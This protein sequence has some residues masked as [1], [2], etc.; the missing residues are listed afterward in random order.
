LDLA[1]APGFLIWK[2]LLLLSSRAVPQHWV[3]TARS[4]ERD[5]KGE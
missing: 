1:A 2:T 4:G 3:R 5:E